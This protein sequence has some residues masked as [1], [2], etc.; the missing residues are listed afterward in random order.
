MGRAGAKL[1]LAARNE[2]ALQD[3]SSQYPDS[4]VIPTDVTDEM[5]CKALVEKTVEHFGKIDILVNNAGITMQVLFEDIQDLSLFRK[6]MDVNYFGMVSCTYYALPHIKE[7]KGLIVGISSVSGKAG[8]PT[9]SAYCGSKH[10][11]QG[12]LDSLRVE[13]MGTGV[14]VSVISPGFVQSEVRNRALGGDAEPMGKSAI[15][16]SGIM[17]AEECARQIHEAIRERKRDVIIASLKIRMMPLLKFLFPKM[18]DNT[19]RRAIN[20]GKS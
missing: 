17:S 5:Q 18:I 11:M 14:D 13:L 16:E 15:D 7:S 8:V 3:V 20:S 6:V 19:A 10:A 12:F 4:L 9:R 1:V 2:E